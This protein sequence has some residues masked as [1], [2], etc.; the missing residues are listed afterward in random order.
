VVRWLIDTRILKYESLLLE[1]DDLTLTTNE[2]LN[3]ATFLVEKQEGGVPKQ[4][5]REYQRKGQ[6]LGKLLS[7]PGSISLWMYPLGQLREKDITDMP[8]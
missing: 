7:R 2:A 3:P 4:M 5:F 8:L 1:K 6:T